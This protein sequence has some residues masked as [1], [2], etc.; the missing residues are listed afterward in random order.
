MQN[1]N[2]ERA[3]RASLT[4]PGKQEQL[5]EAV[6]ALGKQA[7]GARVDDRPSPGYYL[8]RR[9]CT[10]NPQRV[11]SRDGRGHAVANLLTGDVNPS[12]H[13][14]VTWPREVGQVPIFYNTNLTQ[15]PEDTE[16]RYWDTSSLPLY[17]FGFGLS[18]STIVL[19]ELSVAGNQVHPGS[20]LQVSLKATNT[21]SVAGSEVVQLYTH[22][23]AGSASRPVR[24]LKAFSKIA[25]APGE[26]RTVKLTVAADDLSFWSP[27]LRKQV[28]EPGTFDV[29]VGNDAT[30]KLHATF[31]ITSTSH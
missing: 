23:R 13:L 27:S 8:G 30:A 2:G 3:S 10:G 22:Q 5:L 24:E 1:M 7:C 16:H 11:V 28:L 25:L 15:I 14:P 31:E 19:S 29:W 21:S 18:Y 26:S 12:G 6:V 9:A 20:P 17:P 4:L